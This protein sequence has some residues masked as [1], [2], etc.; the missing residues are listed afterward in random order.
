MSALAQKGRLQLKL[1]V[2]HDELN[3]KLQILLISILE[4][5][6]EMYKLHRLH[7]L[8][9]L[10]DISISEFQGELIVVDDEDSRRNP[11]DRVIYSADRGV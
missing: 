8:D 10:Q 6:I 7:R 4:C 1:T 2:C 3:S 9:E 5:I 11:S